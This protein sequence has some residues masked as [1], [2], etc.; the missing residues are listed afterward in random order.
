[1]KRFRSLGTGTST[2]CQ[3]AVALQWR[4]ASDQAKR[5]GHTAGTMKAHRH[6]PNPLMGCLLGTPYPLMLLSPHPHPSTARA[7]FSPPALLF[8]SFWLGI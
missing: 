2:P 1:M 4:W 8:P 5:P 3:Q 7:R 6:T